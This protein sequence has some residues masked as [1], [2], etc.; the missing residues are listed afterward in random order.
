MANNIFSQ[1]RI[2][3]K[4]MSNQGFRRITGKIE[5]VSRNIQGEKLRKDTTCSGKLVSTIGA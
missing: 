2:S 1:F 5:K 4:M 3:N